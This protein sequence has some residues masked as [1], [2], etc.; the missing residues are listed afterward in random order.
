MRGL[1]CA[2]ASG[3]L[4][5]VALHASAGEPAERLLQKAEAPGRALAVVLGADAEVVLDLARGSELLLHVLDP[6]AAKVEACRKAVFEAGLYGTRVLVEQHT[7]DR[8]PHAEGV[9]DAVLAPGLARGAV[10]EA[11]LLRVLRPRGVAVFQGGETLRAP[12]GPSRHDWSHWH[13]KP[14]NG[15]VSTGKARPPFLLQWFN[16]APFYAIAPNIT[17]ASGGRTIFV[18][19]DMYYGARSGCEP[20]TIYAYG[21]HNGRLLWR[22][23]LPA[24]E[25]VL[26]PGYVLTADAFYLATEKGCRVLD[27]ATGQ[28]RRVVKAGAGGVPSAWKWI[29]LDKRDNRL[30]ALLGPPEKPQK[31]KWG[32]QDYW[33]GGA[34]RRTVDN[35][36]GDTLAAFDLKNGDK[37]LWTRKI[38]GLANGRSLAMAGGRIFYRVKG[39]AAGRRRGPGGSRSRARPPSS[40]AACACRPRTRRWPSCQCG[41]SGSRSGG[42]GSSRSGPPARTRNGS[43]PRPCPT[44]PA[45]MSW[46]SRATWC[47]RR[48]PRTR[49]GASASSSRCSWRSRPPTARSSGAFPCRAPSSRTA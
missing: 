8:L 12:V 43:G 20:R 34:A 41:S 4:L 47:S 38:A 18:T 17:L 33:G 26:W 19:G 2:S 5:A 36:L 44:T 46:P 24:G 14:D 6:D 35:K 39:K 21:G 32:L 15:N 37:V 29:A 13:S 1:S 42:A 40:G 7:F 28:E 23:K 27:P 9:C 30:H 48:F 31:E 16:D 3:L 25:P 45:A 22:E 11:E 10:P 49:R